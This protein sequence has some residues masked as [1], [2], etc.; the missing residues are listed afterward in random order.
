[1][2]HEFEGINGVTSHCDIVI[3][4]NVVICTELISNP[5]TSVTNMAEAIADMIVARYNLDPHKLIWLE[6]YENNPN[7]VYDIVTFNYRGGR[8]TGPS[9]QPISSERAHVIWHTNSL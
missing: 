7:K 9:W 6:Q 2:I 1:M 8:F 4:G 3:Q 5:G